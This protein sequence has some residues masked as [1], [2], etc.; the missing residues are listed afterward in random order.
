ML[1]LPIRR[2]K[3]PTAWQWISLGIVLAFLAIPAAAQWSGERYITVIDPELDL[4]S[5]LVDHLPEWVSHVE[6]PLV[7][8]APRLVSG[9]GEHSNNHTLVKIHTEYGIPEV[10]FLA[11][12]TYITGGVQVRTG[13]LF[14][15]EVQIVA[16]PLASVA[17]NEIR[18]FNAAGNHIAS[19]EAESP[20]TP[21]F[22]VTV[23]NFL[24]QYDGEEL[25][26]VT[27]YPG[28]ELPVLHF[29]RGTGHRVGNLELPGGVSVNAELAIESVKT[30]SRDLVLLTRIDL[31]NAWLLGSSSG[32]VI[33]L[34]TTGLPE[35]FTAYAS[36]FIDDLF[37]AGAPESI[38][39]T[40]WTV[41]QEAQVHA[42]DAGWRENRF[43]IHPHAARSGDMPIY[44]FDGDTNGW[45]LTSTSL[46]RGVLGGWLLLQP[47]D[48][49]PFDPYIYGPIENYNGDT[50]REFAMSL[51]V[52]GAPA[53]E[54]LCR[55][56]WFKEGG[57]NT[58]PFN[59]SNGTHVIRRNLHSDRTNE[60]ITHSGT[61]QRIRLDIPDAPGHNYETYKDLR[62]EIDWIAVTNDPDFV[63]EATEEKWGEY[64][65]PA[66]FRHIRTDTQSPAYYP[67][68]DYDNEDFEYWAGG[69][70]LEFI[71]RSQSDYALA[72]PSV[73]EPTTSHRQFDSF[74]TWRAVIDPDTGLPKYAGLTRLN[75]TT[76]YEEVGNQFEMMSWA[77]DIPAL[78]RLL[79]W[80]LRRYLHALAEKFRS[81]EAGM[82][83]HFI[84]LEPNHEFEIN[85]RDDNTIG[86]Y[87]PAMIWAF[88]EHLLRLYGSLDN[89]NARFQTPFNNLGAFD[90]PRNQGRGAWDNYHTTNP[91]FL[92]W[93][94][95]ARRVINYRI[96]QGHREA[97]LAGFPPEFI[98]T[99]QIPAN[100]AVG[101]AE[102][103]GRITP[104]DWAMSAGTSFGGTRYGVWYNRTHNWI[105]GAFSSGHTNI[106]IGEYHPLTTNF[107]NARNQI[108]YLY[109]NGVQF[110]HHMTWYGDHSPN[111]EALTWDIRAREA[112]QDFAQIDSPRPGTTGGIGDIRP[113]HTP[114]G[115]RYNIVQIG[116]GPERNGLLKS[117]N[118]DGSWE[119][120]VYA[121]PFHSRVIIDSLAEDME[122]TLGMQETVL[123][124]VTN[125]M[126]GDQIEVQFF[127][128]SNDLNAHASITVLHNGAELTAQQHSFSIGSEWR[129][130]RYVLRIQNPMEGVSIVLNS[131]VRGSASQN[132]QTIQ[133]QEFTVLAQRVQV[134]RYEYGINSG[135]PHRGGVTFDL[136]SSSYL[137]LETMAN[138]FPDVPTPTHHS[139]DVNTDGR[140][141]LSELLRVVQLHN[142]M[143]YHCDE[144]T[145]D[146]FAPGLGDQDSCLPH[147]SDYAPQDWQIQTFNL[148]RLIQFYNAGAYYVCSENTPAT[149]DG[150]CLGVAP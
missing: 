98:K 59:L 113:V 121:V 103:N 81:E 106:V 67:D 73:W 39:S 5:M 1:V 111:P 130:Y 114:D 62:V 129:H 102:V 96:A 64:V 46:N 63:P 149:E 6:A 135:T 150:Y 47:H 77:P 72:L 52:S 71:E 143:G 92:A 127:A 148:L 107:N 141:N 57:H 79:V 60:S 97:L 90:A 2:V 118:Q 3:Y 126:N 140:I 83:E 87:N 69:D 125:L 44:T 38:L 49:L 146:G 55:V 34:P 42:Q 132:T 22:A 101:A 16:T 9:Q 31:G 70:F 53:G 37:A 139:A 25:A 80:P 120:S 122:Q 11:Y 100:Y 27:R 108:E 131:G 99:H 117:V 19:I 8:L 85:V 17:T 58:V 91:F 13:S 144:T 56:F 136:L 29:Y 147:T 104:V 51:T 112:F 68:P 45:N 24:P 109:N 105:Q 95:H 82:P 78:E 15:P 134:T 40:L 115:R 33:E 32:E 94:D 21:P 61:I 89:I 14:P 35:G 10:Q 41:D 86:D 23:G 138:P 36:A 137:P 43:W 145:E 12:P 20:L 50:L 65:R 30:V 74:S 128:R 133:M 88:R 75:N 142:A 7:E 28:N 116:R 124:P 123:G 48:A 119:G 110:I 4:A 76:G 93:V 26:V 66:L 54:F 18:L 84:A